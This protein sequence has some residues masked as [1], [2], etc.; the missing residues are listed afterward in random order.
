TL[1]TAQAEGSPDSV[2]A[3]VD[4]LSI[5]ALTAIL[6]GN[7]DQRASPNLARAT[8]TSLP[9]LKAYLEGESLLRRSEFPGAI[10]AYQ[11]A[12]AADS[13]FAF[14]LY[15]LGDA[16]GWSPEI[17]VRITGGQ[18]YARAAR[19]ASRLPEREALLVRAGKAFADGKAA[20][21]ELL[22]EAVRKYP[23]DAEAWFSLGEFYFHFGQQL[24]ID[25]GRSDEPFLKAVDLDPSFAPFYIHLIN[26]AF[27]HHA[28]S[29]RARRFI[30]AY[31]RAAPNT[32]IDNESR[33]AFGLAFGDSATLLGALAALDTLPVLTLASVSG[34]YLNHPRFWDEQEIVLTTKPRP[35]SFDGT[36][37]TLRLS[38]NSLN[39]GRLRSALAFLE[40]PLVT[41]PIAEVNLYMLHAKGLPVPTEILERESALDARADLPADSLPDIITFFAAAYAADRGRW[42]AHAFG[43]A[44]LRSYSQRFLAEGDSAASTFAAAAAEG[45]E[46]LAL[47]RRGDAERALPLL[48]RAQRGATG[49]GPGELVNATI[50]WWLGTLH[51]ESGRAREA[52]RYFESFWNDP[53]AAYSLGQAYEQLGEYAKARKAYEFL[54]TAWKDADPELQPRAAAARAAAQ[55]L[56]S[57]TRE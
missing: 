49:Q 31:R 7:G 28:D 3:L 50:R 9:A 37:M 2:F 40:E 34:G 54:A 35:N 1:G 48:E 27:L 4:R 14:A 12:I 5:D 44:R 25:Q 18:Y 56:T 19:H 20:E 33:I 41:R 6:K 42:D 52:A 13:T 46:G 30:Q 43:V 39:R 55:R 17:E 21:V 38:A 29:T 23:D 47:W 16:Y 26:N 32:R 15:H 57:V 10:A 45:L 8:T 51:L 36:L 53:V 22:R 11:R 24:L